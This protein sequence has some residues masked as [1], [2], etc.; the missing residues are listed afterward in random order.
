MLEWDSSLP[1]LANKGKENSGRSPSL[2]NAVFGDL[3][4]H[5]L[6]RG[7]HRSQAKHHR[8]SSQDI[9]GCLRISRGE[10]TIAILR[11]SVAEANASAG[12][13]AE[14]TSRTPLG[15]RGGMW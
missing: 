3:A 14:S 6:G 8:V 11:P 13:R 7:A 10:A 4:K 15:E 12:R 5:R 1:I 9:T 2:G